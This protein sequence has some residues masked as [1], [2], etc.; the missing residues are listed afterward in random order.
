M[1]N[2]EQ[3]ILNVEVMNRCALSF[4]ING[5]P[6]RNSCNRYSILDIPALFKGRLEPTRS[7]GGDGYFN[8]T[9]G[10]PMGI[11]EGIFMLKPAVLSTSLE[12]NKSMQ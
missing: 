8:G 6:L 5:W 10:L 1:S 11:H 12:I 7:T 9:T 2:V 4:P 3:G